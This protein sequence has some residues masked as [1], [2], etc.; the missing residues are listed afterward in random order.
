MLGY[1]QWVVINVIT[2]ITVQRIFIDAGTSA[3]RHHLAHGLHLSNILLLAFG[4]GYS[5]LSLE[6]THS[7]MAD[8]P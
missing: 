4:V 1:S 5:D 7:F 8:H 2:E 3:V 6:I